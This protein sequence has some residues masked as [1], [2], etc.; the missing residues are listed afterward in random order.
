VPALRTDDGR[1]LVG[2]RSIARYL[3]ELRPEPALLP[4]DPRS[5]NVNAGSEQRLLARLP[6]EL[7][8]VDAW[9]AD[10]TLNG[11][12]LNVADFVIA[13]CLALLAYRPDVAPEIERRPAGRLVSRRLGQRPA[14]DSVS[15]QPTAR[16]GASPQSCSSR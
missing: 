3:D 5:C 8:R 16:F 13:Q 12:R 14:D 1:R 7:D 6:A 4:V 9:I 15:A 10:G 2:N 11:E